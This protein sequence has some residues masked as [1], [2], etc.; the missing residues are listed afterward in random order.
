LPCMPGRA[1]GGIT[2]L[3]EPGRCAIVPAV[4]Q[5]SVESQCEHHEWLD[6][7]DINQKGGEYHEK[8][9][10]IRMDGYAGYVGRV[11]RA[12]RYGPGGLSGIRQRGLYLDQCV[13]RLRV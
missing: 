4:G 10:Q 7:S 3:D 11:W 1:L 5:A 13:G 2:P 12:V 6:C 9:Q 8:K